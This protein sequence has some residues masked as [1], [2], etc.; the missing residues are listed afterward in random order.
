MK[1][2]L[3]DH[4]FLILVNILQIIILLLVFWMDGYHNRHLLFYTLFLATFILMLYL[5]FR[6]LLHQRFYNRLSNPM[7]QMD[8]AFE[9]L[10]KA[11]LAKAL[12][13]LL[14]R[15]YRIYINEL[16][17]QE[18]RRNDHLTFINQWVHQMKTPLSVIELIT[19]END[20]EHLESIRE[21]TDKLEKGLEMVLYAARLEMF[22]QDFHVE[23]VSLK[24]VIEEAIR[25]NKRFFIKNHVYPEVHVSST[26][27]ESDEKWLEFIFNQLITNAVKYS[28]GKGH[29]VVITETK[30]RLETIVTVQDYGV[31][32]PKTDLK[33]VFNPFF[34][35]ENGRNYRESTGMG[36]YLVKEVCEK[37]GHK[38]EL[39]SIQGEGTSVQIRFLH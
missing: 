26:M 31:G 9:T 29:K 35:G 36:L 30:D 38:I 16:D 13:E 10:D 24:V 37:L 1:L 25:E 28:T 5:V 20:D 33:R 17:R 14:K 21:E 27:V 3:R 2:F 19:Q 18:K 34:T 22:E 8:E 23:P 11:P 7:N 39:T 15:Q 12:G 4:F 32:I 6:Y